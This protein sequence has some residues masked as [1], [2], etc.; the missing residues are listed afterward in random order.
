M[1]SQIYPWCIFNIHASKVLHMTLD[2]VT[3]PMKLEL[4]HYPCVREDKSQAQSSCDLLVGTMLVRSK[5]TT[6]AR[7]SDSTALNL[8]TTSPSLWC[9]QGWLPLVE[10][11]LGAASY[12]QQKNS[13]PRRYCLHWKQA[14]IDKS[15]KMEYFVT[16]NLH[17]IFYSVLKPKALSGYSNY[18]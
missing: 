3:Y 16:W 8:Y 5:V 7:S 14:E 18:F 11:C 13:V 10:G 1:R 9:I 15:R 4:L 2:A 6:W 12:C 17:F